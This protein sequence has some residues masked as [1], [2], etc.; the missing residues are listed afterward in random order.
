[1]NKVILPICLY[2]LFYRQVL[3]GDVGPIGGFIRSNLVGHPVIHEEQSWIFD[4]DV[5]L[6]RR[7]QFIELNGDKGDKL[8]ER[9]G[10]GIDGYDEERLKIQRVRDEGHLGGLNALLP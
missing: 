6:R 1:M 4:P 8:I 3:C 9:L 7:K 2:V 5:A 10:L